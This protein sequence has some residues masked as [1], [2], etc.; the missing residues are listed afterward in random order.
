MTA[1]DFDRLF[2]ELNARASDPE[3]LASIVA[4]LK[5]GRG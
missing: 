4:H 1:R 2:A 5:E 3:T